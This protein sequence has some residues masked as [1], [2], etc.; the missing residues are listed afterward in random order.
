M[1][2]QLDAGSVTRWV[3]LST[4]WDA[5]VSVR[6]FSRHPGVV[7]EALSAAV[8]QNSCFRKFVFQ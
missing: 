1:M 5:L 8:G 2:L 6:Q 3:C 7:I 4:G